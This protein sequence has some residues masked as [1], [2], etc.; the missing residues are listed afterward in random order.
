MCT[1]VNTVTNTFL[2]YHVWIYFSLKDAIYTNTEIQQYSGLKE[3]SHSRVFTIQIHFSLR[4]PVKKFFSEYKFKYGLNPQSSWSRYYLSSNP[5][6]YQ[7]KG[8][9][10]SIKKVLV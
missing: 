10:C 8:M 9:S 3:V 6:S 2:K 5:N 4:V 1:V 7:R